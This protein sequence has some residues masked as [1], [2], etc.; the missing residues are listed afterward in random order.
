MVLLVYCGTELFMSEV[1]PAWFE[2]AV[3]V[4]FSTHSIDVQGC[5]I[6]YQQWNTDKHKPGLLLIHGNG[7][8]AGWWDFIAPALTDR[9]QVAALNLSGM[10]DSG[11]RQRYTSQLFVTEVMSVCSATGFSGSPSNKPLLLGH[12]FGGR[13]AFAALQSHPDKI[14]GAIMADSPF[15]NSEHLQRLHARRRETKPNKIYPDFD[16]AL[17]RFR[18][19]P[20]QPCDNRYIMDYIGRRSIKKTAEGWTW[21]FDPKVWAEF[22]YLGFLSVLPERGINILA[23]IYGEN[24]RL[25]GGGNLQHNKDLFKGLGLPELICIKNAYHHLL[26]DQPLEFITVINGLLN[27]YLQNRLQR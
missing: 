3:S 18:L 17:A 19:S 4:P 25:F 5:E 6:V 9:F 11:H 10:G 23:M 22:D 12:S 2:Q 1:A 13:L 20:D 26:L 7:A 15:H 21:K 27:Q 16:E 8:H 14:A 24:S